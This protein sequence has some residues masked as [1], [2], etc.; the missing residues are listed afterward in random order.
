MFAAF[1]ILLDVAIFR[2][3]KLEMANMFAAV[4]IMFAIHLPLVDIAV[5]FGFGILLNLLA[6]LTNDYYDVDQDL[7]SPNKDH[8]KAA[9]LKEHMRAAV[10]AQIALAVFLAVMGYLWSPGLVVALIAGGGICWVYSWKLKRYPYVDVLAMISW[11]VAMPLIGF[12][13]DNLLG[14]CLVA[15]LALFSA[16]FESIQIVRDHDEDVRSGVRTTAVRLGVKPTMILLRLFMIL[17]VAYAVLV[18][19]RWFGLALAVAML[20]PFNKDKT[21]IYWNK[22][23]LTMGL[24]WLAMIGWIWW[25]GYTTGFLVSIGPE[26][27]VPFFQ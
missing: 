26:E 9:F 18:L 3:K 20:I 10:F 12:P 13:L 19:N 7:A 25:Y 15:Q 4:A 22:V 14:W 17:S 1:K 16:C 5:R 21:H 27:I 23:R 2:L 6:Y 8:K 11:G 24:V